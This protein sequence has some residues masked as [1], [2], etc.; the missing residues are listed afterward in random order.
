M[1]PSNKP[2]LEQFIELF[3]NEMIATEHLQRQPH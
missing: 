3:E 1:K 2:N